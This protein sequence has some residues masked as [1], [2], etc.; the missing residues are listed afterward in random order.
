MGKEKLTF[1]ARTE[2]RKNERELATKVREK[3]T[4]NKKDHK[5][6]MRV[7]LRTRNNHTNTHARS[8]THSENLRSDIVYESINTSLARS[9][10]CRNSTKL[11]R[12]EATPT[13]RGQSTKSSYVRRA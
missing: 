5:K 11:M 9:R 1:V 10:K 12:G 3:H 13:M 4:D 2:E 8:M 6:D 7:T